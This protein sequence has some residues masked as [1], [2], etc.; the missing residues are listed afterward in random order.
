MNTLKYFRNTFKIESALRQLVD[1][2]FVKTFFKIRLLVDNYIPSYEQMS[3]KIVSLISDKGIFY[4]LNYEDS[5][6]N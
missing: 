3:S 1:K 2:F 4:S 5:N 6:N